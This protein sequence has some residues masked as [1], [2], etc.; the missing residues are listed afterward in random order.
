MF[1][2]L[3]EIFLGSLHNRVSR[4]SPSNFRVSESLREIPESPGVFLAA[5]PSLRGV[6]GQNRTLPESPSA[7]R[8]PQSPP[9]YKGFDFVDFLL[10]EGALVRLPETTFGSLQAS[11]DPFHCRRSMN[12]DEVRNREW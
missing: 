2:S 4:K 11:L 9:A 1:P 8:V 12:I 6:S 10:T 3:Q 5:C 7:P